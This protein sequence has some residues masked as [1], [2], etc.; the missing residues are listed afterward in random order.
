MLLKIKDHGRNKN[1]EGPN[2]QVSWWLVLGE[3]ILWD[4]LSFAYTNLYIDD[5]HLKLKIL[6]YILF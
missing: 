4:A 2:T 3:K 5:I 1:E 6:F